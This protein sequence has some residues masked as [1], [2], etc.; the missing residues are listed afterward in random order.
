VVHV[1]ITNMFRAQY[2]SA[3]GDIGR[4]HLSWVA[5]KVTR[6]DGKSCFTLFHESDALFNPCITTGGGAITLRPH[7]NRP[8]PP[9]RQRDQANGNANVFTRAQMETIQTKKARRSKRPRR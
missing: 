6:I 1:S 9:V 3:I 2:M 7:S 5:N 4:E 8:A